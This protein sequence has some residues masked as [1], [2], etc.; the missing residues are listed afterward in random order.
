MARRCL[1]GLG[2]RYLDFIECRG[3]LTHGY[4]MGTLRCRG[5]LFDICRA[6]G[7]VVSAGVFG[8]ET[9]MTCGVLPVVEIYGRGWLLLLLLRLVDW[10]RR[11]PVMEI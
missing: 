2:M 3:G 1:Q 4:S 7:G 11:L 10:Q 9:T 6:R 5:F 8:G